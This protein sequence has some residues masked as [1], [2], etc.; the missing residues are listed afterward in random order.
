MVDVSEILSGPPFLGVITNCI[1]TNVPESRDHGPVDVVVIDMKRDDG[2]AFLLVAGPA[3][4]A[5]LDAA[6]GM[7][8]GHAYQFPEAL[9][10]PLK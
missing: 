1:V 10:I 6:K 8:P 2:M 5:E 3:T 4:K 9:E 7:M